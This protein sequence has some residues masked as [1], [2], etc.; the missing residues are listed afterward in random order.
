MTEPWPVHHAI[1]EGDD[2]GA[3]TESAFAD[4]V[5][6]VAGSMWNVA[7][8]SIRGFDVEVTFRSKSK[9]STWDSSLKF[10]EQ[11][12]D[13]SYTQVYPGSASPWVFGNQVQERMR[14]ILRS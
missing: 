13:Y 12:G 9:K 10:D 2:M 5:H 14:E 7:R 6:S 8:V 11:S 1:F 3:L 4:I